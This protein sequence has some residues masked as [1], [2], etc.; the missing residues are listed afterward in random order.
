MSRPLSKA[1]MILALLVG[2][3]GPVF[4]Q[5]PPVTPEQ[6]AKG[7][8]VVHAV[9]EPGELALTRGDTAHIQVVLQDKAGNPV[10]GALAFMFSPDQNVVG[11]QVGRQRSDGTFPIEARGPGRIRPILVVRVNDD[12]GSFRGTAGV[13]EIGMVEIAVAD[14]PVNRLEMN[15]VEYTPYVGT[16]YKLTA[17]AMTDHGTE[18]GAAVVEWR[19]DTPKVATVTGGGVLSLH[20]TGDARIV[21]RTEGDINFLY[22]F[23]VIKNPLRSLSIAPVSVQTRTG[24]VV[25]FDVMA[26]DKKHNRIE[27]MALSYSVFGIDSAGAEIF[28]DGSFVAEHPGA[29]RA[30]VSTGGISAEAIIEVVARPDATPVRLVGKGQVSHV[31][32]SDLW[33]FSGKDGRDYAYTGTH[34]QGGGQR[35][36]VWDVTDPSNIQ[37]TDSVMVDARVVNDV[38]VNGDASWAIITREGASDRQ[39]GLV[40]LDLADPAHP[41]ILSEL[42]DGMTSGM[43][44]T[45]IIGN[46]VY[47]INDGRNLMDIVDL[48]NPAAPRHVGQW[49]LR[50][51]DSDKSLHDVW[52]D[53][54][55][56]LYLSYWDDGL[57]ILDAGAGTHGGTATTPAFV[58]S[59]A[60]GMGNTHVA[61]RDRDYVFLGDEIFGCAE[62]TNGPRGYIHVIDV[63][64]INNPREVAKFDVPEAGAHNIWVEDE[65]LYIAYYQG[66]LRIVDVSGDLRG[67]LYA[68]GRQIGW[69]I[70]SGEEGEAVVPNSPLAWGPQ[71]FRGNIFVSDMNSGLW[72]LKHER[73]EALTP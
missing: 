52:G 13:R 66:G 44:N 6:A 22:E 2:L 5:L 56:Y 58:S 16:T 10:E 34:A 27:G 70:T 67:D 28:A 59:I 33:V 26:L 30:V 47:G 45:W 64:D 57:V 9:F 17:R 23:K 4:G 42:T 73:P 3:A 39:N 19:S 24:D 53:G 41:T 32:T 62:C 35:M 36:F 69:Y 20:K 60:Y 29:F 40:V 51:G 14:W 46:L 49:E 12:D 18:H 65:I 11:P 71:P 31:A 54:L 7:V 21:A 43:H 25:R 8:L 37:L 63:S 50:P 68:Q 55:G 1:S 15:E 72:V 61:W 48:S 38:K